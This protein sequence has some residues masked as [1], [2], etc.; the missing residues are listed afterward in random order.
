[1]L[2]SCTE[3]DKNVSIV[4]KSLDVLYSAV[5]D[6]LRI[7][8]PDKNKNTIVLAPQRKIKGENFYSNVS[9]SLT[10]VLK[11][12]CDTDIDIQLDDLNKHNVSFEL[13]LFLNNKTLKFYNYQFST[14]RKVLTRRN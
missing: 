12:N 3:H 8:L 6:S 2:C 5:N 9:L 4:L 7:K 11:N 14:I 1:M 10:L 13:T